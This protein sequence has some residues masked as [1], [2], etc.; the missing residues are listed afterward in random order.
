M[1]IYDFWKGKGLEQSSEGEASFW[2][3]LSMPLNMK[4]GYLKLVQQNKYIFT[5][6]L[7][8]NNYYDAAMATVVTWIISKYL[9][10]F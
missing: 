6:D 5:Q 9:R 4:K 7:P 2:H 3:R 10:E 1:Q 8:L